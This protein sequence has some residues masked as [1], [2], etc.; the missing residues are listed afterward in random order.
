M[1]QP[2]QAEELT[3]E[4]QLQTLGGHPVLDL[5]NTVVPK[6]GKR[7]DTLKNGNDVLAWLDRAGWSLTK[8]SQPSLPPRLL[9]TAR[10]LRDE[11]RTLI[12][13]RKAGKRLNLESLNTFLQKS[14]S[15]LQLLHGTGGALNPMRTWKQRTAEQVLGPLAEAAVELL[16]EADFRLIRRCKNKECMLWFYDQTRSHRRRWC[17]MSTCGN[18]SKVTAFRDRRWRQSLSKSS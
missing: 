7:V 8:G 3:A 9:K 4:H 15:H 14:E 16:A 2:L 1:E 12:E 10:T 17:S 11:I 5:L 13:K 18:R 6:N